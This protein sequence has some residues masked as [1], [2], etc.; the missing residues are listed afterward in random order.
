V[1]SVLTFGAID[2]Q[3]PG[4]A[5]A[6]G[7]AE[8]ASGGHGIIDGA[9]AALFAASIAARAKGRGSGVSSKLTFSSSPAK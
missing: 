7:A 1:Q 4:G 8:V 9:D 3:V 2:S 5:A 6:R